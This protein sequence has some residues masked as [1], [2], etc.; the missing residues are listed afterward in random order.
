MIIMKTKKRKVKKITNKKRIKEM[1][2]A[3]EQAIK[4]AREAGITD[5]IKQNELVRLSL[6]ANEAMSSGN[7]ERATELS[8]A[9]NEVLQLEQARKKRTH[10]IPLKEVNKAVKDT[11]AALER[12]EK[13]FNVKIFEKE[14]PIKEAKDLLRF[15]LYAN[16]STTEEEKKQY[17]FKAM[18]ELNKL[19]KKQ[20]GKPLW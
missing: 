9:F 10:K 1:R 14:V 7:T 5:P 11:R 13:N 16:E 8:K 17:V 15:T 3:R 18:E 4:K 12:L 19:Y 20:K 6:R 2:T